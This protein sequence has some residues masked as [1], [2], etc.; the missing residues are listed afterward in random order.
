MRETSPGYASDCTNDSRR[1]KQETDPPEADPYLDL[2]V[3]WPDA[4]ESPGNE[5][6]D[7]QQHPNRKDI[8]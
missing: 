3:T 6:E 1:E 8:I 4:A 2:S 5:T 7:E